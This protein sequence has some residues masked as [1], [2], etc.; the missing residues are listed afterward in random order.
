MVWN[1]VRIIPFVL[2]H[3]GINPARYRELTCN[4]ERCLG[5]FVELV[6]Y[7]GFLD[8]VQGQ[9][10]TAQPGH[11]LTPVSLEILLVISFDIIMT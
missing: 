1:E 5:S 3:K 4:V 2:N 7:L 10:Y 9:E 8:A 6:P 11:K